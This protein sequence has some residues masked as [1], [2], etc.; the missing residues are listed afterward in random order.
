MTRPFSSSLRVN[1]PSSIGDHPL[2]SGQI[3]GV[4]HDT[5]L[6]STGKHQQPTFAPLFGV[7]GALDDSLANE[8][9]VEERGGSDSATRRRWLARDIRSAEHL[10]QTQKTGRSAG[11]TRSCG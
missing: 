9:L 8:S 11:S 7:H 3:S 5:P 2:L 1:V 10:P 6:S 4:L